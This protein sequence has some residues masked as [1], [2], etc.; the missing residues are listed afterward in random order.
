MIGEGVHA[1]VRA[2]NEM[3]AACARF[4]RTVI[5]CLPEIRRDVQRVLDGL[6]ERSKELRG[7]IAELKTIISSAGEDDD[8]SREESRLDDAEDELAA[9]SQRTRRVE[10]SLDEYSHHSKCAERLA[11]D[12]T[13]KAREYLVSAA[14][15]LIAYLSTQLGHNSDTP[16]TGATARL[17]H[18]N[19]ESNRPDVPGQ[20]SVLSNGALQRGW[21]ET[22]LH[23]DRL[24][25]T[26]SE[27]VALAD[28]QDA[29]FRIINDTL[30][31]DRLM[32]AEVA[33]KITNINLAIEK[34]E[35]PTDVTVFHGTSD[36]FAA[37]LD[38]GDVCASPGFI[39]GTLSMEVIEELKR[40]GFLDGKAIMQILVPEG[41]KALYMDGIFPPHRDEIE[42]LLSPETPLHIISKVNVDGV[43]WIKANVYKDNTQR[44]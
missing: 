3:E 15:E 32:T 10:S 36:K 38:A 34:S 41:T 12:D 35:L 26:T 7:E 42:L 24:A 33:D 29:D 43:T 23:P 2:I 9:V 19:G 27:R 13:T 21:A 20:P 37:M 31:G 39:S 28:Y 6:D 8:V 17:P 4:A 16:L 11:T 18:S 40:K 14:D 44:I 25:L 1:S 30:W 22:F 5:E